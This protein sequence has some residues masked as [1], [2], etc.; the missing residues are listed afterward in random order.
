MTRRSGVVSQ[1]RRHSAR[2]HRKH[3][4][5]QHVCS[6]CRTVVKSNGGWSSHRRKHV[7]DWVM[8]GKKTEG[9]SQTA[10]DCLEHWTKKYTRDWG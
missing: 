9:L 1:K 6:V 3:A 7:R 4:S 10:V 8:G 5:Q 2:K